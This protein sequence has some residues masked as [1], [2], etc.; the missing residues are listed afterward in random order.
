MTAA[1]RYQCHRLGRKPDTAVDHVFCWGGAKRPSMAGWQNAPC[2]HT[3]RHKRELSMRH[4][5]DVGVA[6][7]IES[8]VP[9]VGG[10]SLRELHKL[11][12]GVTKPAR[13][14]VRDRMVSSKGETISPF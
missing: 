3:P 9:N 5:S 10:V 13:A 1:I 12:H 14:S 2:H 7:D 4:A 11:R 6:D 8:E